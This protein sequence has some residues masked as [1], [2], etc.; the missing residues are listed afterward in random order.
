MRDEGRGAPRVATC[1]SAV[2]D[3]RKSNTRPILALH[4]RPNWKVSTSY[5]TPEATIPVAAVAGK[6]RTVRIMSFHSCPK[7][8][9][10][11]ARA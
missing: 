6:A 2:P 3:G 5:A 11:V 7:L 10:A 9:S 8:R 1:E 4:R